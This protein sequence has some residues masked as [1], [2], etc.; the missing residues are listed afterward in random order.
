MF[1]DLFFNACQVFL[2]QVI[3]QTALL[4]IEDLTLAGKLVTSAYRQLVFVL[5]VLQLVLVVLPLD[6][7]NRLVFLLHLGQQIAR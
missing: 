1:P 2:D 6:A 5:F 7:L 4:G 3:Q